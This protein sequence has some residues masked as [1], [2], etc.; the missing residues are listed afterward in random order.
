MRYPVTSATESVL[1]E[2]VQMIRETRPLLYDVSAAAIE[3]WDDMRCRFPTD[4]DVRQ[5]FVSLCELDLRRLR[6]ELRRFGEMACLQPVADHGADT[7]IPY[8]GGRV[9]LASTSSSGHGSAQLPGSSA[10]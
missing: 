8:Y 5:G 1:R 2:I 9:T 7:A 4:D 10:G 6:L 3:E